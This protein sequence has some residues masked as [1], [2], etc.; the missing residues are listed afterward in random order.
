M[1]PAAF[2]GGARG[3]KPAIFTMISPAFHAEQVCNKYFQN[4]FRVCS[5]MYSKKLGTLRQQD[6]LPTLGAQNSK[7]E[8]QESDNHTTL[9]YGRWQRRV[10][11]SPRAQSRSESNHLGDGGCGPTLRPFLPSQHSSLQDSRVHSLTANRQ[12]VKG[13]F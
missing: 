7:R 11:K 13:H 9:S 8:R 1:L 12:E 5:E 2:G 10:R 4:E 6:I 3:A